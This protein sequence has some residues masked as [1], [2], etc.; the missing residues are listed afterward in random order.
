MK[1]MAGLATLAASLVITAGLGACGS[2]SGG[3]P[4]TGDDGGSSSGGGACAP[5]DLTGAPFVDLT[6]VT[7]APPAMT[8]GTIVPGDYVLMTATAYVPDGAMSSWIP[9]Q[10]VMRID[11]STT[12]SDLQAEAD[13]GG[14]QTIVGTTYTVSG[15]VFDYAFSCNSPG[16][17]T[18]PET[19]TATP[20]SITF[21]VDETPESPSAAAIYQVYT[22]Q[23]R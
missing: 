6:Q 21:S 23:K 8:G 10:E 4:S 20:T 3:S 11:S 5:L 1:A 9:E 18:L 14:R 19:Y 22:Y 15:N 13:A 12:T 2:S 17:R 16:V 7:G